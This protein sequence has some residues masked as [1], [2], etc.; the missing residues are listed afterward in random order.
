MWLPPEKIT[1]T[2]E[3]KAEAQQMADSM[4]DGKGRR[5]SILEGGG[6]LLGCLGE[7]AFRQILILKEDQEGWAL[8]IEHKPNRHYDLDVDQIKIDVKTKWAKTVPG[9]LW[10][11]SV[12]MGREDAS[13]LP[14]DVD[15]FAFMR[16][17][18]H[19]EETV[20]KVKVPGPI[21]WFIGWLP[22]SD[23][24]NLAV[25]IK[26]GEVDPRPS[27]NNQFKS[28]KDQ[29]NVYHYQMNRHLVDLVGPEPF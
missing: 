15:I 19:D 23:F 14:Q 7:V 9:K 21:G 11:G 22:K 5:G 27:N 3:M 12:A 18:Y 28:H 8:E 4:G 10:E 26:K 13:E 2:K 20:D 29:W 25:P 16:I 6:D 17:L 1:L 24:Y